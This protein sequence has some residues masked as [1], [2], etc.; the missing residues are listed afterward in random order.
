MNIVDLQMEFHDLSS[1]S[2]QVHALTGLPGQVHEFR[3]SGGS[4]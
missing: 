3:S 2:G 1:S 4:Q